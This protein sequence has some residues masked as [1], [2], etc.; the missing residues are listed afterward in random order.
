VVGE[1]GN[2]QILVNLPVID[3]PWCISRNVKALGLQHLQLS[4]M[5]A[6]SGPPDRACM[7]QHRTDE[8]L[9]EQYT[10]S[11]GQA[12]SPISEEAKQ[13]QSFSWLTSY[14]VDVCR[15]LP[16]CIRGNPKDRAGLT[17]CIGSPR[18]WTHLD[19]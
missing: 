13:T 11:D 14:L 3:V 7:V 9:I 15:P 19:M 12:S 10:F 8:L 18:N 17:D 16:L 2:Q 6:G 4:D 1:N 5:V